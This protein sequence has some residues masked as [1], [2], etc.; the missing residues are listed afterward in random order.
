MTCLN[1]GSASMAARGRND[2]SRSTRS[3][4]PSR[5]SV[6]RP[7]QAA[8]SGRTSRGTTRT[9]SSIL[10]GLQPHPGVPEPGL[11]GG[12]V[13][14]VGPLEVG[15]PGIDD[16]PNVAQ[17]RRDRRGVRR[18][19]RG[20]PSRRRH[21]RGGSCRASRTPRDRGPQA[22]PAGS[23]RRPDPTTASTSAADSDER[24]V[25]DRGDDRVMRLGVH[26]DRAS[27][28]GGRQRRDE[29][30]IGRGGIRARDEHPWPAGEQVRGR[31]AVAGRIAARHRVTADVAQVVG[32]G[33]RRPAGPSCSRRR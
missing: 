14:S 22:S 15:Q 28:A 18:R 4:N 32:G 13:R 9:C 3:A 11:D 12:R 30:H 21:G 10:V 23:D 6:R 7:C 26:H 20:R 5:P 1:D 31:R 27:A 24:Q 33:M 29:G 2:P 19:D 16:R 8:P 17:P 25:A